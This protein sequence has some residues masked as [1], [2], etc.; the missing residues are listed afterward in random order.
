MSHTV[1]GCYNADDGSIE[2]SD[3]ETGCDAATITGCY[4]ASGEHAGKIKI[5]HDYNGCAT[6][7]YACYDPATG[8]FQFETDDACC[9]TVIEGTCCGDNCNT[10]PQFLQVTFFDIVHCGNGNG[11]CGD[12]DCNDLN[13]NTFICEF[14]EQVDE[15]FAKYCNYAMDP[16]FCTCGIGTQEISIQLQERPIAS[17]SARAELCHD[18]LCFIGSDP[19]SKTNCDLCDELPEFPA[20]T[21]SCEEATDAC[22]AESGT[23]TVVA[24]CAP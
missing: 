14:A 1:Y 18:D 24:V 23:A 13:D 11:T 20:S 17:V 7:Y 12:C 19:T 6:Q 8:K 15:V 21:L 5:T 10:M 16:D 3:T 4:V 22:K 2:F 9:C